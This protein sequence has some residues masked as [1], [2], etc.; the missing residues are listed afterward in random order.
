MAEDPQQTDALGHL[1]ALVARERQARNSPRWKT[2]IDA[3]IEEHSDA[4]EALWADLY[5][6]LDAAGGETV[7]PAR[8]ERPEL[9]KRNLKRLMKKQ[10]KASLEQ[11][12]EDL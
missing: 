2:D 11:L 1:L 7:S 8:A 9:I 12:I 5:R 10:L 3:A 6:L 4:C